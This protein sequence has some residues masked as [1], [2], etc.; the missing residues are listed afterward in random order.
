MSA[1]LEGEPKVPDQVKEHVAWHR[2][3]DQIEW[4]DRK[5]GSNQSWYKRL[6]L[7]Q[8]VLAASI[9]VLSIVA[10][11][12]WRWVTAVLG[13]LIVVL[14]GA[15]QLWQF[16]NLWISYRSTAEQLKHEKYLF[17]AFSGPYSGLNTDNALKRLS[18]RV[19]EQVS[20]EHAKWV[21]N[22][23]QVEQQQT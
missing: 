18:E 21:N 15:Q 16:N 2:L 12:W 5:S 19:E 3:N 20:T 1:R 22:T 13:G 8:L 11:P 7:A 17:L 9:P 10:V 6:K 4:Y 14:E 23:R